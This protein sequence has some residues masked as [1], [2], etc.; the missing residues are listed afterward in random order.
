[1][2][3][4]V[5]LFITLLAGLLMTSCHFDLNLGQIQGNGNVIEQNLNIDQNFS[6]IKASNGWDVILTQGNKISVIAQVDENLL[7]ILDV[8]VQ[9]STLVI[10]TDDTHNV[11]RASSKK[12][13]VTY[14]DTLTEIDASSGAD[15]DAEDQIK[16]EFIRLEASSGADIIVNLMVRRIT[17]D[18]SSGADI[19]ILGGA[20]KLDASASSGAD[21][22]AKELKTEDCNADASSGGTID[23]WVSNSITAE[24]SSG[25][26]V[27]YWG[28]PSKVHAPKNVSGSV[29]KH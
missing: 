16:G 24:A 10:K 1:M 4:A 25:G 19:E 20:E 12:I 5:K 17:A 27:N 22:D 8:S 2:A 14:V 7:E 26:D 21:I 15:V 18:A 28:N 6:K 13:H 3:A 23:V 29:S 11:G 9:G